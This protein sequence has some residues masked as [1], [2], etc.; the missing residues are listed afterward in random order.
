MPEYYFL[1]SIDTVVV[2]IVGIILGIPVMSF[3]IR[4]L[5]KMR[6]GQSVRH[7]GPSTHLVKSGTPT[8][9]GIAIVGMTLISTVVLALMNW[10][11]LGS[12]IYYILASMVLFSGIGLVDDLLK[13]RRANSDGLS[14]KHKLYFQL[15]FS[16]LLAVI[17]A[18]RSSSIIVPFYGFVDLGPILYGLLIVLMFISLT[19]AVN[20]T[21]G[22]D[23]LV[24]TV[25][26][27]V[28]LFMLAI[29]SLA[30]LWKGVV[31]ASVA[32]P[33]SNLDSMGD[34]SL[35]IAS[36]IAAICAFLF[37]NFHPSKIM[38]GDTGSFA[39]GGLIAGLSV[40]M[41]ITLFIPIF[42]IIFVA[43]NLC[44]IIQV[45]YFKK[46]GKRIFKM[47]PLHHHYELS[48]WSENKI[49][50][51][52][53][54]VTIIF[55]FIAFWAYN[56]AVSASCFNALTW[57]FASFGNIDLIGLGEAPINGFAGVIA[58]IGMGVSG[59]SASSALIRKGFDVAMLDSNVY[60]K[61]KSDSLVSPV[62]YKDYYDMAEE[63]NDIEYA[64]ISP[65]IG[66]NSD[67]A[68]PF[69]ERDINIIGEL[70]LAYQLA[71]NSEFIGI[72]GTNGKT[73][74]TALTGKIFEAY[75]SN[76][77][78]VGNIG[79]PAAIEAIESPN[80]IFITEISSF[81][82]EGF[83]S[84]ETKISAI[85]NL[86]PDHLDRHGSYEVYKELKLDM[87]NRT[88]ILIYNSDD[89]ELNARIDSKNPSNYSFS[90]KRKV[91]GAY[92]EG[93][94][95]FFEDEFIC[96][97]SDILL[98]GLHNLENVLAS[99]AISSLY[100]IPAEIIRKVISKFTAV[101]HRIEFVRQING[102]KAFNDSK[103]TNPD[104]TIKAIQSM[105]G[106]IHLIAG[107][108]EKDSDFGS[109]FKEGRT[110]VKTLALMGETAHRMS[111]Q[112]AKM[113][114][115]NIKIVDSMQ[116]AVDYCMSHAQ[117]GENLLLSPACASWGMYKDYIQRGEDFKRIVQKI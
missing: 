81:Q 44:V 87:A 98:P 68:L 46:T 93:D 90:T 66:F 50:M 91:R 72:T 24:G 107:G 92:L 114:Y 28:L 26:V 37:F 3:T 25:S 115:N 112:A 64:V 58:V 69:V 35:I 59:K 61:K 86:K 48:G 47:S 108:Y 11:K 15:F 13:I 76:V 22:V 19:N 96:K 104:S 40:V 14:A 85:L 8:M 100:G 67:I 117:A 6:L 23:G 38:M 53:T 71:E 7:D 20:L 27:F 62:V 12:D 94:S 31:L 2:L 103:G 78:I 17:A 75:R 80:S 102:I 74:V 33:T 65:G 39:L 95:L 109:L 4:G 5:K 89:E 63:Y 36:A 1:K 101:E 52:F 106:A 99:I 10:L 56:V 73:T 30:H 84:F 32:V 18:F 77:R 79:K 83:K 116:E 41:G 57:K 88:K 113:G 105:E 51:V 45:T 42:G 43:E 21:D 82:I 111:H 16:I 60:G 110:R 9:G 54:A 70:E 49:V 29:A 97:R 34:I 55:C